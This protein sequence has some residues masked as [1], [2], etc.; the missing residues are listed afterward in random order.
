MQEEVKVE[1]MEVKKSEIEVKNEGTFPTTIQEEAIP[2]KTVQQDLSKVKL[3][4]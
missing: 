3:I 2:V 1:D 4:K